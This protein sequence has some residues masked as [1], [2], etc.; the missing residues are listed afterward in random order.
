MTDFNVEKGDII[1]AE[2]FME[3]PHFKDGVIVITEHSEES[4]TVGFLINKTLKL[5]M[6]EV[7]E[8]FPEIETEL[9]YGGPVQTDTLHYIHTYGKVLNDSLHITKNL[10]W[11]GDFMQLKALIRQNVIKADGIRFYLGYSGWS[12]GQ[13]EEEFEVGTWMQ[14]KL[15]LNYIF[16]TKLKKVWPKAM[17]DK[18]NAFTVIAKMPGS[19]S[20]N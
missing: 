3:N 13:L 19:I 9:L 10:Y 15:D 20:W 7:V 18:G 14:S 11:G 1:L 5:K 8:E 16:K 2:P 17:A 12:P 4:G 6:N